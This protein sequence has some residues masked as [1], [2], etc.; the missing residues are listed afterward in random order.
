M[1]YLYLATLAISGLLPGLASAELGLPLYASVLIGV[2]AT[3]CIWLASRISPPVL[4]GA[5]TSIVFAISSFLL[6]QSKHQ[7]LYTALHGLI[8]FS[9]GLANAKI[10]QGQL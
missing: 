2:V 1:F 8:G 10:A 9:V 5:V 4:C 6:H 7:L 3:A